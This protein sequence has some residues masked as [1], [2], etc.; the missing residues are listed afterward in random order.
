MI[1]NIEN[2]YFLNDVCRKSI[3]WFYNYKVYKTIGTFSC[4]DSIS[5]FGDFKSALVKS[6]ILSHSS[7]TLYSVKRAYGESLLYGHLSCIAEFAH[8]QK[9]QLIFFPIMEHGVTFWE[10]VRTAGFSR[11]CQGRYLMENWQ[12]KYPGVPL[13]SIGPYIH[14]A[15]TYYD[16]I[17]SSALKKKLG[18]VLLVVPAHTHEMA[19]QNYNM[20][21]FV[22]NIMRLGMNYDTVMILAYWADV[23]YALYDYF[24]AA[25]AI[26][27]SAGFR[28]DP[29]F[30]SRLKTILS[31]ADTVVGNDIGTFIGYAYYLGKQVIL[32]PDD[33]KYSFSDIKLSEKERAVY[34]TNYQQFYRAFSEDPD[35]SLQRRLCKRFWGV[36]LEKT[37]EQLQDILLLN[38]D[39][40]IRSKGSAKQ[41]PNVVSAYMLSSKTSK[42]AYTLLRDSLEIN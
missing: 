1:K 21:S 29:L 33:I 28:G 38:R 23:Q 17:K 27:V 19:T 5:D 8:F 40:L 12:M 37:V 11:V 31:L 41:I 4:I 9:N 13:F 14:Y 30:I 35:P 26:V 10:V 39:I 25:G 32:L 7:K 15:N 24:A 34:Q 42:R 22:D 2:N 36:G 16:E 20:R 6:G 18:K 3:M